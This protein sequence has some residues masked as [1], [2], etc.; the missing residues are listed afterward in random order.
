[1]SNKLSPPG[2]SVLP[3]NVPYP[4]ALGPPEAF[5]VITLHKGGRVCY[6]ANGG[7]YNLLIGWSLCTAFADLLAIDTQNLLLNWARK[8]SRIVTIGFTHADLETKYAAEVAAS[9]T[10]QQVQAL[11]TTIRESVLAIQALLKTQGGEVQAQQEAISGPKNG[12]APGEPI[13]KPS[14]GALN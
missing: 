12:S 2:Q 1:M 9:E 8:A 10:M 13:A 14:L 11:Q 4:S 7:A 6:K 5:S 3:I